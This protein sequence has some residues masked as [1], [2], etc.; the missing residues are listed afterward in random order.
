MAGLRP[1]SFDLY[2]WGSPSPVTADRAEAIC[3]RLAEGESAVTAP[4]PRLLDF[5]GALIER[6]PRLEELANPENSPWSMSPDVSAKRVILCL[7]F[8]RAREVGPGIVE[9]A[10]QHDLICYDPQTRH[11]HHPAQATPPGVLRLEC[12]DGSRSFGPA[13][14]E[15]ERQAL[16][17]NRTNWYAW[18]ARGEGSYVQVGLGPKAGVP[19]DRYSLEYR[20]GSPER[21]Y[22]VVVDNLD[23]VAAAFTG[24]AQG[25]TSWKSAH[26]WA[27]L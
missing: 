14:G 10:G 17:L 5:A 19:E 11:V 25:D 8:S 27:R 18:L 16:R 3:Q 6:Y 1:V 20:D 26:S 4:S 13:V 12:A 24:F 9:L 15:I 21:H 2:L 23:D 7:A 22:R